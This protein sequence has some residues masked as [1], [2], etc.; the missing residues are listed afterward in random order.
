[1]NT[2]SWNGR[3]IRNAFQTAIALAE[4]DVKEDQEGERQAVM[5]KKQFKIIADASVQFD[6][7][8]FNVHG[9][10][11]EADKARKEQVRWDHEIEE[12]PGRKA[13]LVDSSSESSSDSSSSSSDSSSDSSDSS[14]DAADS[15]GGGNEK[16]RRKKNKKKGKSKDKDKKSKKSESKNKNSRS[17][18]DKHS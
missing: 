12:R 3:Q 5:G 2:V 15:S 8:L 13:N 9:Q 7:Y 17:K 16:R 10:A 14:S 1:M 18:K 11:T 4:F 6:D